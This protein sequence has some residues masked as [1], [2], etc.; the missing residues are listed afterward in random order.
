MTEPAACPACGTRVAPLRVAGD[1]AGAC[2]RCLLDGAARALGQEPPLAPGTRLGD[3]EIL[4]PI[5][6]GGMGAVYKA[7]QP[8]LGRVVALKILHPRHAAA[9]GFVARF[10]REA[11]LLAGLSH[12]NLVHVY[13]VGREGGLHY[14]AMEHVDGRPVRLPAPDLLRVVRDVALALQKVHDA[15]LVHRDVKPANI[16]I[17]ADGTPKLSDFGIALEPSKEERLTETGVFVGSPHYAS[18]EHIEG[19]ALDGR[20]DLYA[21]GVVLFEGLAGHPPF[22]GPSSAVVLAKHLHEAPPLQE[23]G[24]RASPRLRGLVERLLAKRPEDRP[25]RA[26][27]LAAELDA[28]PPEVPRPRRRGLLVAA[29]AAALAAVSALAF[30]RAPRPSS[31]DL[32]KQLN[33]ERDTVWGEWEFRDG[34][35]LCGTGRRSYRVQFPYAVPDEYDLSARVERLSGKES[36]HIGLSSGGRNWTLMLDTTGGLSGLHFLDGKS[37]AEN[38]T[39]RAG[40][41]LVQGAPADVEIKVRRG[42]ITAT[43]DGRP[44]VDWSGDFGRLSLSASAFRVPST[45]TVFLGAEMDTFKVTRLS[46]TPISGAGTSLAAPPGESL[47]RSVTLERDALWGSW[48]REGEGIACASGVRAFRLQ[49]PYEVPAEYDYRVKLRRKTDFNSFHVGLSSGGRSFALLLEAGGT[50]KSINGLH[51]ID[52]QPAWQ[53]PTTKIRKLLPVAAWVDVEASVRKDRVSAKVGGTSIV[54]WSGAPTSLGADPNF[55]IPNP[56]ILWFGSEVDAFEIADAVVTPVTGT[57]RFL[58]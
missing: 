44:L 2:P 9:P 21:L 22:A 52:G 29:G 14:L 46:L 6:S 37:G 13:D 47:L 15:G 26:A 30:R 5:G 49:I 32:L 38:E 56:R 18:P 48:S 4:E 11:R 35:L 51:M 50:A 24:G 39:T 28:L 20:S 19:R 27:D 43:V 53:N 16:L 54:D 7:R 25:A 40:R 58:P 12:P 23:L 17:A 33:L 42:R 10:E 45:R 8:S 3:F 57:G 34:A 36:F 1:F 55:R 41:Q 31:L